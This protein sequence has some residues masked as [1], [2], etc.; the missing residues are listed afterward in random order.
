MI[1][2][3]KNINID[4]IVTKFPWKLHLKHIISQYFRQYLIEGP[5]FSNFKI[6]GRI[7]QND[8]NKE[9]KTAIKPKKNQ[10]K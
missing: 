10:Q 9:T 8:E 6:R 4:E 7:L 3:W 2:R 5:K 1:W